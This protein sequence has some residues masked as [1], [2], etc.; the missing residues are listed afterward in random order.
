MTRRNSMFISSQSLCD[1]SATQRAQS[2]NGTAVSQL[3]LRSG[4]SPTSVLTARSLPATHTEHIAAFGPHFSRIVMLAITYVTA[5]RGLRR[6]CGCDCRPFTYPVALA[7]LIG[8]NRDCPVGD[9][10]GGGRSSR[11]AGHP[12]QALAMAAPTPQH[13]IS[14]PAFQSSQHCCRLTF[15][16]WAV[17]F[18]INGRDAE[19]CM[20]IRLRPDPTPGRRARQGFTS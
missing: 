9:R 7:L 3:G 16:T 15:T 12:Q 14:Q 6:P 10:H 11:S 19:R 8:G 18:G 13:P 1:W 2:S 20:F 4:G 5:I 17:A